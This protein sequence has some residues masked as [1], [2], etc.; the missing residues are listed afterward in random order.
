MNIH[1]PSTGHTG[2]SISVLEVAMEMSFTDEI[3][4]KI[5]ERYGPHITREVAM[6]SSVGGIGPLLRERIIAQA[7]KKINV[8][9]VALLYDTVWA[10]N[11]HI[12]NHRA[13][14]GC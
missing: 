10:Q 11:W 2:T 8:I 6:S 9:G 5:R 13:R 12:W 7:E 1:Q 4:D 14:L 3:L